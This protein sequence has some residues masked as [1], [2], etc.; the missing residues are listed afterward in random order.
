MKPYAVIETG[1]K[2]YRVESNSILQ[3]ERLPV[4]PGSQIDLDRVLAMSDGDSLQV[5][6]PYVDG[7]IVRAIVM[8]HLQGPKVVSFKYKRR[9]GYRRKQGHRQE[10]TKLKIQAL[11]AD[12]QA[13]ATA[14]ETAAVT[15]SSEVAS[16]E[17][18]GREF[19][20]A[21]TVD[22]SAEAPAAPEPVGGEATPAGTAAE[23]ASSAE[24]KQ[25]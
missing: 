23:D 16:S 5:G 15:P 10:L 14:S 11:N 17:A 19:A 24:E 9:K 7:A 3:V 1:G 2:Q 22:V 4:D 12:G 6:A 13:E 20:P 21:E 18:P 25:S 8:E